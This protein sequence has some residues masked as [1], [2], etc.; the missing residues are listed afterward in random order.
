MASARLAYIAHRLRTTFWLVPGLMTAA[1]AAA[2]VGG[3]ALDRTRFAEGLAARIPAAEINIEGARLIL[4]TIAGATITVASLVF[5]LT[6]VALTLISQ[7]LGPRLVLIVMRDRVTQVVLGTFVATFVYSLLVLR[8]IGTDDSPDF[9]PHL[10]VTFA[11]MAAF[12]SFALV[13]YFVHHLAGAIQADMV[14]YEMGR[15]LDD[16]IAAIFGSDRAATGAVP[17]DVEPPGLKRLIRSEAAGYVQAL[18]V[19]EAVAVAHRSDCLI[20]LLVRPGHFV[21]RGEVIAAVSGLT[22]EG[23]DVDAA[24]R[25]LVVLGPQRTPAQDLEFRIDGLAEIAMR[26]L[27]PGINDP[28]TAIASI[29]R[30]GNALRRALEGEPPDP[31]VRDADGRPRVL[32]HPHSFRDLLDASFRGIRQAGQGKPAILIRLAEAL[33]R[34]ADRAVRDEDR[35]AIRRHIEVIERAAARLTEEPD[36]REDVE[37]RLQALR[38]AIA[39][40]PSQPPGKS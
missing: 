31:T 33:I 24:V 18:E 14:I 7:Q 2:A 32:L 3:V 4:S 35:D 5:S 6:F 10:S 25:S 15:E 37:R 28:N 27:S 38:T 13:I 22:R 26:A 17:E 30:L 23:A 21:G 1:A 8:V 20:R 9:V 40:G 34:L 39:A 11:I 12:A 29:D 19:D 36:D 16:A